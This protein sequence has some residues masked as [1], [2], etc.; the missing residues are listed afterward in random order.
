MLPLPAALHLILLSLKWPSRNLKSAKKY[1]CS[2]TLAGHCRVPATFKLETQLLFEAAG[3]DLEQDG[4]VL[5]TCL[6]LVNVV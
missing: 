5:V 1:S 4:S 2:Q 6:P 3:C